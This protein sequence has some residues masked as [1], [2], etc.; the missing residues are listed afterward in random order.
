[1]FSGRSELFQF[2]LKSL[3]FSSR[4][5]VS[6]LWSDTRVNSGLLLVFENKVLVEHSHV[7][8]YFCTS[9]AGFNC[10]HR[11]LWPTMLRIITVWPFTKSFLNPALD[12][13]KKI[14]V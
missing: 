6:K 8:D 13:Y 5:G 3:S 7:H 2:Y 1:M 10:H 4:P 11:D 14:C 9:I 12:L